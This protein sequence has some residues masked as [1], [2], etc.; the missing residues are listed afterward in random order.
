MR[1][2]TGVM[3]AAA[4]AVLAACGGKGAGA[5]QASA[6]T[7][8]MVTLGANDL[9]PAR[10]MDLQAGIALSGA[11]EPKVSVTVGAPIAEQLVDMFVHEGDAVRQGQPIAKFRDD[12]LRV[13]A[14]SAQADLVTSRTTVANAI[15][16]STRAAAL[17]AEGA[18]ARK[19]YDNAMVGL[20]A[21][22]GRLALSQSQAAS[23]SDRLETATL[24]APVSG[25]VSQ[26][27]AQAGDRVD[28]GKPVLSI[29]DNRVLQL[30]ASVEA[31]WLRDISV[32]RAVALT[33]SQ[34]DGDTILGRISRIS[35][36]ADPATR[37]VRL[38]VDIPNPR[39]NL[40]GGLYVS[41]RIL[42]REVRSAVA[43]PRTAVRIEG[44]DHKPWVY[45]LAGGKIARRAVTL[46][47]EDPD[48]GLVQIV[49][50]VQEGEQVV[51]GPVEGLTD[52]TRVEVAGSAVPAP[53]APAPAGGRPGSR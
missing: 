8:A 37:Q 4:A 22:R 5:G 6:A 52:G 46:G 7:V 18:I 42:T 53:A 11:M 41:G 12:V 2:F 36:T 48:R 34:M 43:V 24:K 38:Y 29:V 27:M 28:F 17:F 49:Q 3:A 19:D 51:I 16:D 33:I 9:A 13:A 14:A 39:G 20:E 21:A 10:S 26:R 35:P 23:A 31:R 47:V 32:G 25:V 45:V 15:S 44:S 40:V 50:G 30:E 1:R